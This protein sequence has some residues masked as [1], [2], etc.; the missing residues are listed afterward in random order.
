L[1][2]ILLRVFSSKVGNAY[3]YF[4]RRTHW[5]LVKDFCEKHEACKE[6]VE[7]AEATGVETMEYLWDI[8]AMPHEY[9]LW[10]LTREGAAS[11]KDQRLFACWCVRRVWHLLKDDRSK[12]A[13]E[14]SE[15]FAN[16]EATQE[17]LATARAAALDAASEAR[18]VAM[19]SGRD[20]VWAAVRGAW[21]AVGA[22]ST[23]DVA[24]QAMGV[25]G[26][27][28]RAAAEEDARTA[29]RGARAAQNEKLLGYQLTIEEDAHC[30]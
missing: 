20:A 16:G 17:E 26:N 24:S 22:A 7:W 13:V 12:K 28:A 25:A 11:E 19:G 30:E 1:T 3:F 29:A 6:V 21:D 18:D 8:K 14:V 5:M 2:F 9:R 23:V 27:V 4:L 15:A 10:I